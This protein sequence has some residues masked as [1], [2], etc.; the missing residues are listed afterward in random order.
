MKL[1]SVDAFVEPQFEVLRDMSAFVGQHLN[2]LTDPSTAWQPSDYLPD[3]TT[4]D[5]RDRLDAFRGSA[6]AL[7]DELLVVLVGNMVTEE[8]LP[9]YA[10]SLNLLADDQIGTSSDPW[11]KWLRGWTAEENRHG[12]LLNAF[13]RLT[14]RVDMRAVE[15]TVHNLIANGFNPNTHP[16]PYA[17]LIY[18]S[19]Q[20]RATRISHMNV[21][22]LAQRNGDAHLGRICKRIAGDEARHET[23]YTRV[24]SEVM[25]RDAERGVLVFR[26]M[27]RRIVSMPGRLMDDCKRS[28]LFDRFASIAQRLKV[29]TI[30]DYAGIF[31]HL[32]ATWKV[33]TLALSGKA[34]DAQE[35]LCRQAGRLE[36][37]AETV[38]DEVAKQ[39]ST[40]FS[41]IQGRQI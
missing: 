29:Y 18:T 21:G 10:V 33:P 4:E 12:D 15:V 2:L 39:E 35:F 5:W 17:G 8:A 36:S 1:D 32:V 22:E 6:M 27:L 14:G 7:S 28:D 34:A 41:W 24:M 37:L 25:E 13:L 23:F 40:T 26:E 38:S 20:E 30:N 11:S 31:R 9:N 3:F 19:F 16:N